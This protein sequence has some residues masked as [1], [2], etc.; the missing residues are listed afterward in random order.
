MNETEKE[1]RKGFEDL[2]TRNVRT[3]EGYTRDSRRM[4]RELE[5][6]VDTLEGKLR[7]QDEAMAALRLQLANVQA[8]VYRGG[9]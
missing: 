7:A 4:V 1:M 5:K 2:V 6:K 9:T 8:I 3:I